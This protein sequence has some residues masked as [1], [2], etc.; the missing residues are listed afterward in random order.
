MISIE[1][2]NQGEFGHSSGCKN[3]MH[4]WHDDYFLG[5]VCLNEHNQQPI[6]PLLLKKGIA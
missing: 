6:H 2:D 5:I 4:A 3:S 1:I